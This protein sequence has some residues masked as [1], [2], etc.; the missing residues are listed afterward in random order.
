MNLI[1]ILTPTYNREATLARLADSL[2]AQTNYN[3]EWLIV[4]DGSSDGTEE[5]IDRYKNK[6][7]FPV[8]LKK[9]ENGGKHTALNLGFDEAEGDWVFVVDSDDWLEASC[10]EKVIGLTSQAGSNVGAVSILRRFEDGT[11]IGDRFQE[12][13]SNYV[14]RIDTEVKGDKA[15][16]FKK[17]AI[18]SFRFPVF[19]GENFMAES[20]LFIWLGM[21]YETHFANYPGYIT[22]Y[23]RAGLSS[24]SVTNRYRCCRSAMYVYEMQYNN[25]RKRKN[26]FKAAVNWWRFACISKKGVYESKV[27]LFYYPFALIFIFYDIAKY[28]RS[29]KRL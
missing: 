6:S 29:I 24:N 9:K 15:D 16:L 25:L 10:I 20:P 28:G 26:K 8:R 21:R 4:D 27:P 5:V 19:E 22:E 12:N 13:L 18:A 14:D 11:V 1:T 17:S 7:Q 23:Q 2:L 3:F